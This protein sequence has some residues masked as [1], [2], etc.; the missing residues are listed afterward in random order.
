MPAAEVAIYDLDRTITR[1]GTYTPFL[2]F[3]AR[4][5]APWRLF[6]APVTL[7]CMAVYAAKIISRKKLKELMQA[8]MMGARTDA[9]RLAPAVGAFA[10]RLVKRGVYAQAFEQIA[11]DRAAGR[12]IV[13]ATAAHAFYVGA[14]AQELGVAG[15][16]ATGSVRD[17]DGA[18]T[19][20]IDGENCY[21]AAKLAM[22]ETFLEKA[23]MD[24]DG[25]RVRFYSDHVSD[26]PV[27]DWADERIAVNPSARLRAVAQARGWP[28]LDWRAQSGQIR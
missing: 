9:A 16:V 1:S 6:L 4:R 11:A 19:A 5:H 27:F 18:L 12:Q 20:R 25:T 8:L 21:G 13:L 2:L 24:R 26:M 10:A 17:A 14:I 3:W 23:G 28:V 7:V 15:V 22:I